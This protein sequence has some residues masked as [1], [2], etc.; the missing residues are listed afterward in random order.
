MVLGVIFEDKVKNGPPRIKKSQEIPLGETLN[1]LQ[2][3]SLEFSELQY[4]SL[5]RIT[6]PH[7][8]D[9]IQKS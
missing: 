8:M 4:W 3:W 1:D 5:F 7:Y 6:T 9:P 2:I